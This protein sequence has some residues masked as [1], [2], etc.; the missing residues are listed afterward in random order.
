MDP[1]EEYLSNLIE[2]DAEKNRSHIAWLRSAEAEKEED[3]EQQLAACELA[4]EL[5]GK[6]A[7]KI[8][9]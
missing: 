9:A 4:I 5:A 6:A 7:Q 2:E 3:R 1:V 8:A